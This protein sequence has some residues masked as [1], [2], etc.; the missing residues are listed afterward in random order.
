MA[1]VTIKVEG[2]QQLGRNLQQ[3]SKEIKEKVLRKAARV[4]ANEVR[5][6]AK[7]IVVAKGLVKTGKMRDAIASRHLSKAS[8]V[9]GKEFYAVGVFKIRNS[10]KTGKPYAYAN[11]RL[12]RSKRRVGKAYAVDAPEFYWKFV[13]LGTVKMRAKP[14]LV[15]AFNAKKAGS[16]E[17]MRKELEDGMVKA[18]RKL[19]KARQVR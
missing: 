2:L 14:F 7:S 6:T 10:A 4:A 11:T 1:S 16:P 5:D 12:N 18:T 9:P 3:F 17:T 15:P 13:E 8:R 19:A